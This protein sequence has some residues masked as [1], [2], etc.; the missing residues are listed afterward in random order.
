MAPS[1][2][3][4]AQVCSRNFPVLND[5]SS[6]F[7]THSLHRW[8]SFNL[9]MI[10]HHW[11]QVAKQCQAGKQPSSEVTAARVLTSDVSRMPLDELVSAVETPKTQNSMASALSEAGA[12]VRP[13][14][15]YP[16]YVQ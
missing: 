1:P 11:L 15:H 8:Q 3:I 4:I 14:M 12:Q 16:N 9:C 13:R 7:E 10:V 6:H 5:V 2:K